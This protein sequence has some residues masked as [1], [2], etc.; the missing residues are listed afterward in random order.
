M[1]HLD[2][3]ADNKAS[4]KSI[5]FVQLHIQIRMSKGKGAYAPSL[6]KVCGEKRAGGG[7]ERERE[8]LREKRE[9]RE[10]EGRRKFW[11]REIET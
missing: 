7:K 9:G 6:L 2:L 1:C 10:E 8:T 11:A 3:L 5:F 4:L